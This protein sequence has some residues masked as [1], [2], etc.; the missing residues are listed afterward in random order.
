MTHEGRATCQT[1]QLFVSAQHGDVVHTPMWCSPWYRS[2][3]HPPPH[4]HLSPFIPLPSATLPH[5]SY[6]AAMLY[7]KGQQLT[8]LSHSACTLTLHT[9]WRTRF[10]PGSTKVIIDC[11]IR[12]CFRGVKGCD[13]GLG[14]IRSYFQNDLKYPP[15]DNPG[16]CWVLPQ[17]FSG[18]FHMTTW[19]LVEGVAFHVSVYLLARFLLVHA[20]GV[21]NSV[22]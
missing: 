22:L 10:L 5:C 1:V 7:L 20:L 8:L 21:V 17:V 16:V 19:S 2:G 18:D 12:C 9:P 15:I 14:F 6:S 13:I 3:G 4:I 11:G